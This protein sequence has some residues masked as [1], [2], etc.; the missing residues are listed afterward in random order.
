[1]PKAPVEFSLPSI[2]EA[3]S[4]ATSLQFFARRAVEGT[5]SGLHRS[6]LFGSS[7]EFAEHKLYSPGD[8]LRHVDWKVYARADKF[9]LKR[10]EEE[11]NL[12]AYLALDAS[13]SMNF[14]SIG[15]TKFNYA[16][17]LAATLAYLFIQQ[18][19]LVALMRFG[20][21]EPLYLP[22]RGRMPHFQVLS[23]ILEDSTPSGRFGLVEALGMLRERI[24]KKGMVIAISDF[25]TSVDRISQMAKIYR[26]GQHDVYWIQILDPAELEFPFSDWSRFRGL[27]GE[28]DI[29]TD[30]RQVKRSYQREVE[31]W[32]GEIRDTALEHQIKYRTVRTNEPIAQILASLAS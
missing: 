26:V 17:V 28:P 29:E 1:M 14:G 3:V 7:I 5:L 32:V 24:H 4:D 6:G 13:A 11:T 27:E 9:Y 8:D 12:R 22:P 31:R 25:L 20:E 30:A 21:G 15:Y 16:V 19:D 10:F 23:E 2:P 18:Q